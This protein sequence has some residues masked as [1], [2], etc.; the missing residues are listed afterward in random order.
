MQPEAK[1]HLGI[2]GI[3][4]KDGRILLI[5]KSRGPY[6]GMLDFPGGRPEHGESIFQ[7]LQREVL[8]ETG[9]AVLKA[10]LHC[11]AAFTV[12]YEEKSKA[13]SLH[14]TVLIY[15]VDAFD[16]SGLNATL[17]QEDAAGSVWISKSE[18]SKYSIS[19]VIQCVF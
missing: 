3:I 13:I 15:K 12:N 11:N 8:E 4:E 5:K 1:F 7:T 18:L 10:S 19:K 17:H 6:T 9:V 14:H 16:L 2:Y